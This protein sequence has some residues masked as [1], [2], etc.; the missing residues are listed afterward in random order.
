MF[1]T[2]GEF[3]NKIF[4]ICFYILRSHYGSFQKPTCAGEESITKK[5]HLVENYKI[6]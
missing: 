3:C 6:F 1:K 4:K 5:N 2:P